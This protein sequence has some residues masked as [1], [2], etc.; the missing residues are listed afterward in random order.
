V[1]TSTGS[2]SREDRDPVPGRLAA[3]YGAIASRFDRLAR[4][5]G[6]GDLQFLQADDVGFSGGEP[7]EKMVETAVHAVD[8]EGRDPH[9][10]TP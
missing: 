8:V 4:K 6:L 2:A 10:I 7:A 5:V 3:P 1:R 9:A